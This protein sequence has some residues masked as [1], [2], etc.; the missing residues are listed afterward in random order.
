MTNAELKDMVSIARRRLV[1]F[2]INRQSEETSI[3]INALEIAIN[4]VEFSLKTNPPR[5]IS[6]EEEQWFN[7]GRYIELIIG[8]SPWGDLSDKYYEIIGEVKRKNFFR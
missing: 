8:T 5:P 3:H 2:R 7:A 6:K 4:L 1:D